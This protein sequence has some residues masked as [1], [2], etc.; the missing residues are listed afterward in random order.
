MGFIYHAI[1]LPVK[2]ALST[3]FKKIAIHN[4]TGIPSAGPVLVAVNHPNSFMEA[5]IAACYMSRTAHFIVRGDVFRNPVIAFF[6]KQT[7]QIPIFRF[8][9]GFSNLKK[10][11][12]TMEYCFR[13]LKRNQLIIIFSEGL[14]IQEKRLRPIQKGT[15]RMAFGAY[16]EKGVEN[17][18]IVPFGVNYFEGTKART[19]VMCS[20]GE[21]LLLRDY[22]GYYHQNPNLAIKKLTEDIETALRD[23]VVHIDNPEYDDV[24]DYLL[25]MQENDYPEKKLA[26]VE[27]NDNR[28]QRELKLVSIFNSLS[29]ENAKN[30]KQ[31]IEEYRKLLADNSID[32]AAVA[33]TSSGGLLSSFLIL[34]V[35]FVPFIVG[36]VC[37]S[38]M[39]FLANYVTGRVVRS[40]EFI[41]SVRFGVMAFCYFFVSLLLI[42]A[43]ILFQDLIILFGIILLPFLG[44]ATFRFVERGKKVRFQLN[45]RRLDRTTREMIKGKRKILTGVFSGI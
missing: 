45:W 2:L 28:L 25:K 26:V 5:I 19:T 12:S 33:D 10:N 40:D 11:E 20:Y 9:D 23:L 18:T 32:D 37:L 1:Y 14:C 21:P 15:A 38:W 8:K 34:L 35:L 36:F 30:I 13:K 17:L 31:K 7:N 29:E 42:L 4:R 3:Y 41:T 39:Y 16:E 44:T 6:L 24:V 27:F 22:L 43:A